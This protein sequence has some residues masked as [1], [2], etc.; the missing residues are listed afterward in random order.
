MRAA[1]CVCIESAQDMCVYECDVRMLAVCRHLET[2]GYY[3]VVGGSELCWGGCGD[4]DIEAA[5]CRGEKPLV[6]HGQ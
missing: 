2:E 3:L 4:G 5:A 6:Q 1:Q